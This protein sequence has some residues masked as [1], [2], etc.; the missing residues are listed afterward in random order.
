M[1]NYFSKSLPGV[2][3]LASILASAPACAQRRPDMGKLIATGGVSQV[4]GAGGGGLVPWALITGYG[5]RDSWGANAH[6]TV[7]RTQDYSLDS[8]GVAVGIA[9]RVEVS[10]AQQHLK[11]SLAP[12]DALGLTQ[13]IVG[14]KLKITG[15][16]VYD[17]DLFMPQL[18][19]GAL[20]KR[21]RGID[22]LNA[23]GVSSVTHLGAKDDSGVDVYIAATKIVL[24]SS[25]LLN[26]TLRATKANQMGLLGF[27]GERG[28]RTRLMPEVSVAYMLSR[29]LVAGV[30]YR[31]RP[32]NLGVDREKA[33]YDAFVA[34]F[35]NKHLSVTAAY[36][37]LG[38][39]TVFNPKRQRGA[40]LSV[41]AGF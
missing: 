12:L 4:E 11:G 37:V 35:P 17:Q 25:L 16:A 40:Y 41:Q 28:N 36:V 3:L 13:D 33:N 34:W 38:D 31:H 22:G 18:A 9:D 14:I 23:L 19:V 2:L 24:D 6:L 20:Y 8:V 1:S 21:H 29:K 30:E 7:L 26:G 10:L 32:H 39:I 15:D 27:G 5:T